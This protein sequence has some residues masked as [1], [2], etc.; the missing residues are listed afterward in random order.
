[1]TTVAAGG[2]VKTER[3]G[4]V[5]ILTLS[6]PERRNA[7]SLVLRAVLLDALQAAMA[8]DTCRAVVITGEGDHFCSG[9]DISSFD[10][11]TPA[12]GRLRMQRVHQ[13]VRLIV[14]GEKP[15][16]AAVEG[17]AAGAGLCLAA[18]C[19]MVV[20]S[21]TATFSCT[22][23]KIGLFPDLG[24][25]WTIPLRMG[26]GKAKMLMMG[27]RRL[28]GLEAERQGLVDQLAEPG[29]ALKDALALAHDV[30]KSAPLSNGLVKAVLSR[31]PASLEEVM[32]AEADAQG[33]LYGTDDFQEGRRAFLEKRSP[34]FNGR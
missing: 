25:A 6:Y 10:G 32:A 29:Q 27:G 19:D 31:G 33:V 9:G 15:V 20:A 18:A 4:P 13:V 11:V 2:T 34:R 21:K 17:H 8:D 7:L 23:N 3:S 16:I 14:R 1:M 12:S 5:A 30:S 22:F 26:L 28:D 24:G